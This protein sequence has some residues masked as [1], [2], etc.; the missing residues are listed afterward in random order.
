MTERKTPDVETPITIAQGEEWSTSY[1]ITGSA[2]LE[3]SG[4][5]VAQIRDDDTLIAELTLTAT[6]EGETVLIAVELPRATS[7]T[8]APGSYWWAARHIESGLIRFG[9]E[10]LVLA[11]PIPL[12]TTP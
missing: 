12:A 10:V 2:A 4:D 9:G 3:W 7:E 11:E 5:Y 6:V 1:R 8:I